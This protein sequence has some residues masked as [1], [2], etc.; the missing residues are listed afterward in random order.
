VPIYEVPVRVAEA[1]VRPADLAG[2]LDSLVASGAIESFTVDGEVLRVEAD[3]FVEFWLGERDAED[4]AALESSGGP[5]AAPRDPPPWAPGWWGPTK[6]RRGK[7]ALARAEA[8]EAYYERAAAFLATNAYRRLPSAQR[9]VW[10]LHVRGFS[11]REIAARLGCSTG[12]VAR[13]LAAVRPRAGLPKVTYASPR[14]AT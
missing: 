8:R 14:K 3:Q 1:A 11:E 12:M 10:R 5:A 6:S 4:R 2:A 9:A 13:T 7:T